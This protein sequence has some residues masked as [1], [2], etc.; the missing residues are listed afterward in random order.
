VTTMSKLIPPTPG[1]VVWYYPSQHEIDAKQIAIYDQGQ[2]LAATVAY[3]F[4]DRLVNLSVV[5]QAGAQFRRTSV[6][7]LQ[8]DDPVPHT[9]EGPYAAWMPYQLGQAK[10]AAD[11]GTTGEA[12]SS[13]KAKITR[14]EADA[15]T[16]TYL[17]ER[18]V[19]PGELPASVLKTISDGYMGLEQPEGAVQAA[20][21]AINAEAEKGR[22]AAPDPALAAH[23][24]STLPGLR[25][26]PLVP[27]AYR[28][29]VEQGETLVPTD[30]VQ[31]EFPFGG[32]SDKAIRIHLVNV[33]HEGRDVVLSVLGPVEDD[34][35]G[36]FNASEGWEDIELS[37]AELAALTTE[38]QSPIEQVAADAKQLAD[39]VASLPPEGSASDSGKAP[40]EPATT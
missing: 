6:Q 15:L 9:S 14:A 29:W 3:V 30:H 1:R 31:A 17:G 19:D 7:L 27:N 32:D 5:D 2:P 11:V 24:S 25:N 13:G 10:Q 22:A 39:A 8:E 33:N 34:G 23:V 18:G 12:E 35:T 16:L 38:G 28:K 20:S 4:S 37:P 40:E 21:A 36:T 26:S